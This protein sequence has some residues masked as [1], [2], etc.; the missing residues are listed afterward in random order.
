MLKFLSSITF[1]DIRN[2]VTFI[3]HL[4]G[5]ILGIIGIYGLIKHRAKISAFVRLLAL[6][7]INERIKRIKGTL[8]EL[9]SLSYDVKEQRGRIKAVMGQ[10]AGMI[11]LFALRHDGFK[12]VHAELLVLVEK[13]AGN[14]EA[15]KRR[16]SEELH[17]LLDE[18]GF[19]AAI[20]LVEVSNGRK[21][22]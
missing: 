14:S 19:A 6:N 21:N 13:P 7:V 3:A 12:R 16:I 4:T 9:D 2:I 8:G 5:S 1:E 11:H 22:S 10:L 17:G 20:S 18:Q 15:N